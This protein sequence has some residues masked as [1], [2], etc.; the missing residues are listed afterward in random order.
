MKVIEENLL[1]NRAVHAKRYQQ[2]QTNR[3]E[4]IKIN[5]ERRK[6]GRIVQNT[7]PKIDNDP[8]EKREKNKRR[9]QNQTDANSPGIHPGRA[10]R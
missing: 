8:E 10:D 9:W 1:A 4:E 2:K 3:A 6:R 7:A 5:A